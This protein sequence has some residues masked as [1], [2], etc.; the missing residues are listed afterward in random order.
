MKK[1]K[2]VNVLGLKSRMIGR[3]GRVRKDR[4]KSQAI[5]K[6]IKMKVGMDCGLVRKEKMVKIFAI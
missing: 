4:Q 1:Q 5:R 2:V 3:D 6:H